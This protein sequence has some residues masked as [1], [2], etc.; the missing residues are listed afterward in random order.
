MASNRHNPRHS[1]FGVAR[2]TTKA[3]RVCDYGEAWFDRYKIFGKE[4]MA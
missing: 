4:S 2:A 1:L 3:G